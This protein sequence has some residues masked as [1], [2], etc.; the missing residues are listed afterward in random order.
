MATKIRNWAKSDRPREKMSVHGAQTLSK[1]EL[2]AI[3][4]GSG[5]VGENVVDLTQRLLADYDN[6]L[7]VLARLSLQQLQS[8][9]GIGEAKAVKLKAA[10]QLARL[11]DVEKLPEREP[12]TEI[13]N[14]VRYCRS[15]FGEGVDEQCWA[16][17]L[18]TQLRLIEC[19]LISKGGVAYAA[20]DVRNLMR[21]TLL[22]GATAVI[23]THNH[24]SGHTTPSAHDNELTRQITNACNTLK[25]KLI[26][27]L[28]VGNGYYSYHENGKL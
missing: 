9:K 8:Y 6:S 28:I 10:F 5:T 7:H 21:E 18:D 23:F 3:L 17:M 27:H 22:S 4:L 16:L 2:L 11:Y 12:M 15:L 26:D 14:V 25:I 24:P 19:K 1:A 13:A 20:V